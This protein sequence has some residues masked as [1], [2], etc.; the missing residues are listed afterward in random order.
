MS[1]FAFKFI[2]GKYQGGEFPIP[3][4]GELLI[5]RA[6]DLDLVLVED[7]VSRKHAKLMST[8]GNLSIMDLGSTNGTFVNGEK[9][10]RSELK[11]NDRILIGTSILKII[12]AS[13]MTIDQE[14][15]DR[16]SIKAMLEELAS[17]APQTTTMSGD[18]EE[19]P[20]PD[21]LQLFA[22]NKKS[23]VL[24]ISGAHR[25][26]IY[27]KQ[28]Q[29]QSAVIGGEV[30]MGPMKT[31]CRMINW[32]KG[33]FRLEAYDENLQFKET[34]QESTESILIEALRQT[35]E[36]RRMMPELPPLDTKLE[37]C[38]PMTPKLSAL[39]ASEIDT[40]QLVLNFN[41]VKA[42]IDKTVGTDHEAITN[43]HKLLREGY[44]EVE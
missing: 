1:T 6:S 12:D 39:S 27:I 11:K 36:I 17:R 9:I 14:A 25:G 2:S 44:I 34:F 4:E 43:I 19:V 5:G 18:L 8:A 23:G 13:E 38:I 7:M 24:T 30:G 26:K 21:L 32:G 22:T 28:G 33:S 20:L 10:R 15:S 16:H 41:K 37:L 42:I 31:I 40:V 35:D 29:I 3:E